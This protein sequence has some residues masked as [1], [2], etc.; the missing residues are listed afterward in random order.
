MTSLLLLLLVEIIVVAL[1]SLV[2]LRRQLTA[3]R[4]DLSLLKI[5]EADINRYWFLALIAMLLPPKEGPTWFASHVGYLYDLEGREK[6]RHLLNL[7]I[8]FP[9]QFITSW[10]FDADAR[11]ARRSRTPRRLAG[12]LS[13]RGLVC[14]EVVLGAVGTVVFLALRV[15][16]G[17]ALRLWCS[18]CVIE[19]RHGEVVRRRTV[20]LRDLPNHEQ[21]IAEI[22]R[23]HPGLARR[24][25]RGEKV[26]A[27]P[28][29][30]SSLPPRGTHRI[31]TVHVD[32]RAKLR[33]AARS[34]DRR[35]S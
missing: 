23:P 34:A 33:K 29:A 7:M 11:E 19:E 25:L 13:Y 32:S 14:A 3:S 16:R 18:R 26:L 21:F 30:R 1:L 27:Y 4:L 12:R 35:A 9:R 6:R 5:T 2:G 28:S 8:T 31:V 20:R 15:N 10:R 17:Q 24:F 22:L